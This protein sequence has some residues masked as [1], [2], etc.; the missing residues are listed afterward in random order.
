MRI[1]RISGSRLAVRDEG[2]P[3]R[4]LEV[5]KPVENLGVIGM[6]GEV[7]ERRDFRADRHVFA[8]QLD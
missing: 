5:A 2:H 3:R 8:E 4:A 1:Q 6:R 7:V